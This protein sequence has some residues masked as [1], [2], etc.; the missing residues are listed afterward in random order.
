[1]DSFLKNF[2]HMYLNSLYIPL[3][4]PMQA[5]WSTHLLIVVLIV[6][7]IFNGEYK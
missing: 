4:Y 6:L 2:K 1:M 3:I 5:T 7:M